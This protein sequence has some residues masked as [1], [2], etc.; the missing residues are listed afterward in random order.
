MTPSPARPGRLNSSDTLLLTV[1]F[2]GTA[3]I[4]VS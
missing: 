3:G 2:T 4:V 1:V